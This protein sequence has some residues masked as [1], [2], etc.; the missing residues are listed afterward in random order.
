MAV[1]ALEGIFLLRGER[2]KI[3]EFGRSRKEAPVT[4]LGRQPL[5]Y[6]WLSGRS[7]ILGILEQES[8][9]VVGSPENSI[10]MREI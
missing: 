2:L 7:P 10:W 5:V 3:D 4:C 6:V 1:S 8:H 9:L